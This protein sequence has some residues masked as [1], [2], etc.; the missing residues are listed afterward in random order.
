MGTNTSAPTGLIFVRN[1]F[2]GSPTFQPSIKLIKNGYASNI[3][4]GDLVITGTG[5][6]QGYVIL[7]TG[8]ESAQLGV[9]MGIT[10]PPLGTFG[11][12]GAQGDGV[13]DT[14]FQ[15]LNYGR[16]GA[17][18]STITP[19]S[20]VNIGAKVIDDPGAVF[21]V[22]MIGGAWTQSLAGQN[23][24]FTAATNGAPNSAGVSILS[25][26]FASIGTGNQLPFRIIGLSGAAPGS[27]QDPSN[28][29]PWIEVALNTSEMLQGTGI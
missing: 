22:Q 24:N 9:F 10:S 12:A 20:G 25:A 21:A 14:N 11:Q 23:I 6:S 29:N 19:P 7:S 1:R 13:F 3:G 16:N 2:S 17:Y 27:P 5:A 4:I 26:D 18:V 28:T 8:V 15:A